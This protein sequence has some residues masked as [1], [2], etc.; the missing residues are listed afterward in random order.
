MQESMPGVK[1]LANQ[2]IDLSV[3]RAQCPLQRI[4]RYEG[5]RDVDALRPEGELVE[6]RSSPRLAW[7]PC[8]PAFVQLSGATLASLVPETG[9]SSN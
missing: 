1:E 2:V 5:S 9:K 3:C 8:G 7:H 4:R 6:Q